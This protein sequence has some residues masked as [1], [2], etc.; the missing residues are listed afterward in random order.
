[1]RI[2]YVYD[3][4]LG[5]KNRGMI[6]TKFSLMVAFLGKADRLEKAHIGVPI[7]IGN[8]LVLK[9]CGEFMVVYFHILFK[10]LEAQNMFKV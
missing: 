4:Y 2:L 7:H 9:L 10:T 5:K 6:N 1:M 3:V 8:G